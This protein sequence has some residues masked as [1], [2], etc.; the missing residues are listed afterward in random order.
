MG[1]R[2]WLRRRGAALD[3]VG[4]SEGAG[5]QTSACYAPHGSMYFDQFGKVR[6]CCQ[7]DGV[8][9][10]DV[11]TASLREIWQ[12]AE[13]DRMRRALE[14]D[15]YSVGCSFCAWQVDEGGRASAFARSFDGLEPR[16]GLPRYPRQME[17][18][19]S[20]TCNL[21][22]AMCNGDF[23]STIR[24]RLERRAPLAAAYGDRFFDE[25]EEFLPHL[26]RAS[27]LGGEPFL[28]TESLRVLHMLADLPDPPEVVITTN[29]TIATP[30]VLG[31][32]ETLRP[33]I[34]V[35]LD[36]A[37]SGTYESIRSGARFERVMANLDRFI[38]ILGP[39]GVSVAHCLMTSNWSE[40]DRLLGLAEERGLWV[41]VNVVRYPI[42]L[43]LYHRPAAELGHV[44]C[45]LRARNPTSL[46]DVRLAT[47]AD[48]LDSLDRHRAALLASPESTVPNLPGL[49]DLDRSQRQRLLDRVRSVSGAEPLVI[50]TSG[51]RIATVTDP[52][53]AAWLRP[54]QWVGRNLLEL[55]QIVGE[56]AGHRASMS[57]YPEHRTEG[58]RR[59][60]I[61][62][63]THDGERVLHIFPFRCATTGEI[64][65]LLVPQSPGAMPDVP[66]A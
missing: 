11:G 17:F 4:A 64:E 1:K 29:G 7:N 36:G 5:L 13:A 40:F 16:D 48:T 63:A 19:L 55:P 56:V 8:H 2:V 3:P 62:A 37:T 47:W 42:H 22:C 41:G 51:D 43:S 57:L 45:T 30:Q 35:S 53:W 6:A 46:T 24:S 26:E 23:S 21:S 9:L 31:L 12:S 59:A 58:V 25:L 65:A 10:G 49:V 50:G 14:S 66:S 18:A 44:V 54:R 28:A 20:N 27:F 34:V 61:H 39:S 33:H 32:I 15:D 60:T 38:D 52:E